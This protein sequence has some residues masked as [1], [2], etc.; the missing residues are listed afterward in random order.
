METLMNRSS[1]PWGVAKQPSLTTK[2]F[3][4]DNENIGYK[5]LCEFSED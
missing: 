3:V 5:R 4:K 2:D 1:P